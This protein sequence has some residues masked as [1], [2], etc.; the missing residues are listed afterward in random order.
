MASLFACLILAHLHILE[1]GT[2]HIS[3][4]QTRANPASPGARRSSCTVA[5]RSLIDRASAENA[6]RSFLTLPN[7]TRPL[8]RPTQCVLP[9]QLCRAV[10]LPHEP[11]LSSFLLGST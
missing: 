11:S 1:V 9:P 5:F 8:L 10:C 6:C 4:E 2:S 7:P 3:K